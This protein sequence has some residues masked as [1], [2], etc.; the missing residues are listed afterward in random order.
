MHILLT[1][2]INMGGEKQNAYP[3]G[4]VYYSYG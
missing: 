4:R 1:K 3:K 2:L